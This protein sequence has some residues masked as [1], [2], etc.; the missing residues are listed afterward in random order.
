MKRF[1]PEHYLGL[2]TC[3]ELHIELWRPVRGMRVILV[4]VSRLPTAPDGSASWP[5]L[6]MLKAMQ[7]VALEIGGE[8][9]AW[10]IE[11]SARLSVKPADVPRAMELLE[12][13]LAEYREWA[14]TVDPARVAY[15]ARMAA[16]L[17]ARTVTQGMSK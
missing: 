7:A 11:T 10:G 12:P 14:N 6:S 15:E 16:A 5:E 4:S 17:S 8:A 9:Y 3:H 1:K 13:A 2:D